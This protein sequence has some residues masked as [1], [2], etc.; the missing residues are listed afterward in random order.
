MEDTASE[1]GAKHPPQATNEA[2][3]NMP[4]VQQL[5]LDYVTTRS[6]EYCQLRDLRQQASCPLLSLSGLRYSS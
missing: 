3:M 1:A 4:D 6:P 2:L 5:I